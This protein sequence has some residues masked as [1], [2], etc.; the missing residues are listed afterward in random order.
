MEKKMKILD[1]GCGRGDLLREFSKLD[2]DAYGLDISARSQE[3][4]SDLNIEICDINS[5]NIPFLDNSFDVVFS[6]SLIGHLNNT[7]H[8]LKESHRVLREGGLLII[9][10]PDWTSQ[11]K[12]IF[13]DPTLV[14]FFTK[15]SLY[16]V[17]SMHEFRKIRVNHFR[18]IPIVWKYHFLNY[19][20]VIATPFIPARVTVSFLRWSRELMLIG[21]CIK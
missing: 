4:N 12:T 11:Y 10:S 15:K 1:C 5:Q 8:L 2:L 20:C 6:K 21:S 13:D 14:K 9:M 19:I 16:S 18:Q 3:L 7:N 17:L